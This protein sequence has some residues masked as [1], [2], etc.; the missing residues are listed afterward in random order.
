VATRRAA[1]ILAN[2]FRPM[3]IFTKLSVTAVYHGVKTADGTAKFSTTP[4][5]ALGAT[6]L[7]HNK[8]QHKSPNCENEDFGKKPN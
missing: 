1:E 8:T 6:E 7:E 3:L 4:R 5:H 2:Q